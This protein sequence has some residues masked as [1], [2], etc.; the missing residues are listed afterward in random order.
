LIHAVRIGLRDCYLHEGAYEHGVSGD[1]AREPD[2]RFR[3]ADISL[4]TPEGDAAAFVL[5]YLKQRR[6]SMT[7]P[8]VVKLPEDIKRHP[9]DR[10][11]LD[12]YEL[13]GDLRGQGAAPRLAEMFGHVVRYLPAGRLPEAYE[14]VIALR[15]EGMVAQRL[16]VLSVHQALQ[17][18]GEEMPDE[19]LGLA[20]DVAG[21]L[22]SS[23]RERQVI[24]GADL[25]RQ[26]KLAA[27]RPQ[28]EQVA[29]SDKFQGARAAAIDACVACDAAASVPLVV[30]I[31]GDAGQPMALRQKAAQALGT[32][33]ND[34]A[35]RELATLLGVA[36]ASLAG[37]LAAGLAGAPEPAELLLAAIESGKTSAQ[38]LHHPPVALRLQQIKREDLQQ[39]IARLIESLPPMDERMRHLVVARIG[40]FATAKTDVDIGKQAFTKT[41]AACHQIGG[42]GTKIG[43]DLDGIGNRGVERLVED[44]LDPNRNV[45]QAFR[46]TLITTDDGQAINGLLL[47]KEGQVLV[48]SD[49]QGKE[50]RVAG[51]KVVE[52]SVSP[53][54]PMPANVADQLSE[55]DFFHLL[56]F[57]LAQNR[58][59]VE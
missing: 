9:S 29:R 21:R 50:I 53:L 31:A 47:R 52:Q 18:R 43:P 3:I 49:N 55:Q 54:S 51:D 24:V 41:C 59:T 22:L 13:T 5:N 58:R 8:R 30:A 2:N 56:A 32:V 10:L 19:L 39:R 12:G 40:G 33:N 27:V 46:T 1:L 23:P 20:K 4:G 28:L 42:E 37:D 57:L 15:S 17:T 38:V 36:P 44:I 16:V 25:A 48:L 26:L 45:D 6:I 7:A 11:P 14:L 35:H 34:S